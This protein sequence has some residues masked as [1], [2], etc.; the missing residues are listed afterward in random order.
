V[1][2]WVGWQPGK[3]GEISI[4]FLRISGAGV[5]L[6]S[7]V[8]LLALLHGRGNSQNN[9][10]TGLGVR[11]QPLELFSAKSSVWHAPGAR[12]DEAEGTVM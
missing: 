4:V 5:S 6:S 3:R 11:G 7:C 1:G 10:N 8:L 12:G 9:N 2:V